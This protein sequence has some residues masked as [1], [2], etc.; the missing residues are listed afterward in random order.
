MKCN[1]MLTNIKYYCNIWKL[2]LQ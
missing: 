1:I 2:L